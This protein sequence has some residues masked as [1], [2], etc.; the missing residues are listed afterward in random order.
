M[1]FPNDIAT[2]ITVGVREYEGNQSRFTMDVSDGRA[3]ITPFAGDPEFE[4]SDRVWA[5]I[6]CG[7]LSAFDAMRFKL[8]QCEE[9]VAR[10]LAFLSA[11]H[12]PFCDEYF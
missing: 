10:K 2:K 9:Q 12:A 7:G 3:T 1:R 5:A 4:C 6:A 8:A 11:G